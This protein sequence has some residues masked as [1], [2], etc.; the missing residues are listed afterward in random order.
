MWHSVRFQ[1]NIC[2]DVVIEEYQIVENRHDNVQLE[3]DRAYGQRRIKLFGA[4]RQ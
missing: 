2:F 1:K 3:K 4:P